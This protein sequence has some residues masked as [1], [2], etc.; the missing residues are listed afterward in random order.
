MEDVAEIAGPQLERG[1]ERR[2]DQEQS[3]HDAR[4]ADGTRVPRLVAPG[5][6]GPGDVKGAGHGS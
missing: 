2:F 1:T 6:H 4:D 3:D 5:P